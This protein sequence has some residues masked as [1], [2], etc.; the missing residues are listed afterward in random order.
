MKTKVLMT[1]CCMLMLGCCLTGCKEDEEEKVPLTGITVNPTSLTMAV[2]DKRT[3]AATPIPENA[4]DVQFSW[5]S[6]SPAIATVSQAGE[7]EAKTVSAAG[8]DIE[9]RCGEIV[10]TVHVTVAEAVIALERIAVE[11]GNPGEALTAPYE[12]EIILGEVLKLTPKPVPANSTQTDFGWTTDPET[13]DILS[14]NN[15]NGVVSALTRGEAH[16]VVTE[17][18][19]G[20]TARIKVT[21][22][23]KVLTGIALSPDKEATTLKVG[24]HEDF[25]ATPVPEGA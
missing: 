24:Q 23:P 22:L 3:I 11:K 18:E 20:K 9:V 6:K 16:V 15:V 14:V 13:T 12:V 1:A 25:T 7:V 19:S 5:V 10:A 2:G 8:T 21:V 17:S 4:T